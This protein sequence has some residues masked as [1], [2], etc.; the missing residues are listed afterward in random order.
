MSHFLNLPI[1][2]N[3]IITDLNL[4]D[5]LRALASSPLAFTDVFS[6]RTAGG[7]PSPLPLPH[8]ISLLSG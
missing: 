3:G 6:A 4:D 1:N 7:T 2:E 5:D 8:T